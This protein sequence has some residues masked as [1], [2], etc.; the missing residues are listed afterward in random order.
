M[1]KARNM[2]ETKG[3]R[4]GNGRKRKDRKG[5]EEKGMRGK[6]KTRKERKGQER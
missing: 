1:E 6:G 5:H 4:K 3:K 2:G